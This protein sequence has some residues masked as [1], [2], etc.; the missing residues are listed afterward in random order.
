M[1]AQKWE[2]LIKKYRKVKT[3]TPELIEALVEEIRFHADGSIDID[4]KY[5]NEFEEMFNECE[6]IRKEVA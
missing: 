5:M 3:V 1:G 6:R 4:F 2:S